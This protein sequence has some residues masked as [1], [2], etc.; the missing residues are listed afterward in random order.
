MTEVV[1]FKKPIG[2]LLKEGIHIQSPLVNSHALKCQRTWRDR[3]EAENRKQLSDAATTSEST[4]R[5][6]CVQN[7]A[8]RLG[9]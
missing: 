6:R 5:H 3:Q 7:S 4:Q 1:V 8:F 9:S 2:E